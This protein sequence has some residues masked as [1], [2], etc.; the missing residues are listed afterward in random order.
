MFPKLSQA[1]SFPARPRYKPQQGN[2]DQGSSNSSMTETTDNIAHPSPDRTENAKFLNGPIMSHIIRMTLTASFGLVAVFSV[3]FI[4]LFFLSQLDDKNIQ[5]ALGFTGTLLFAT[6]SFGIGLSIA[7][8]AVV[9]R[10]AGEQ[11][12]EKAHRL[13]VNSLIFAASAAAAI[14]II[15]YLLIEPLL[16]L[17]GAKGD[18][19]ALSVSYLEILVPTMPLFALS[20]SSAAC[21]RAHG[22]ALRAMYVT[23][24]GG[25]VNAAFDPVLIFW[26]ELGMDGAALSTAIARVAMMV[27]GFWGLFHIHKIRAPIRL[28]ALRRDLRAF[29][30]VAV[31]SVL[32]NIATPV[33]NGY[34]TYA[35]ASFGDP[36]V[37]AWGIIARIVP[38]AF[39]VT[40]AL[41]GAV[42]PIIGQNLG[43]RKYQ[44]VRRTLI[45]AVKFNSIYA[46][47]IWA[48]L[49]IAAPWITQIMQAKPETADL[50]IFFCRWLTPGF[51]MIGY[52]FVANA[53]FNNV[54]H[55]HYSSWL[56]WG[57][58]TL[59][60]IPFVHAGAYIA[61][62]HGLLAGQIIGGALIAILGIWLSFRTVHQISPKQALAR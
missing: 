34:V 14:G 30:R 13:T 49:A 26:F 47:I 53:T 24:A 59:G 51:G 61:G 27:I 11:D 8:S 38:L 31:P 4:D 10:A 28:A 25:L 15:L 17:L 45:D 55:A 9:S 50:V 46:L 54:D 48:I 32:T 7:S 41:S 29:M 35:I 21:L 44:R 12:R 43:G 23:I 57:R 5:A 56:N 62:A 20:I 60:T 39:C 42:G 22:D 52:L 1:I 2:R 58:A 18:V 33:G 36:A 16:I 37:A 19:L 3:D 6:I 40:F